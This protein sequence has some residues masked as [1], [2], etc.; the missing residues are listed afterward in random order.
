M[1]EVGKYP[2]CPTCLLPVANPV[3][4][5]GPLSQPDIAEGGEN[6]ILNRVC[7][8]CE[9]FIVI[10]FDKEPDGW[11]F[12]T[13]HGRIRRDTNFK[14]LDED[15]NPIIGVKKTRRA[16]TKI[17]KAIAFYHAT[18]LLKGG[19]NEVALKLGLSQAD[20]KKLV[21]RNSKIFET[22]KKVDAD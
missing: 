13:M 17:R 9:K 20:V 10:H 5:N 21:M 11:R 16:V 1:I 19:L 18:D 14:W 2:T 3:A 4:K 8:H 6:R 15:G 12:F 22:R 7:W